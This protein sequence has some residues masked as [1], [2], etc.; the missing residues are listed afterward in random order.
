MS[1]PPRS[2]AATLVVESARRR[3]G[4]KAA[5]VSEAASAVEMLDGALHLHDGLLGAGPHGVEQGDGREPER[6]GGPVATALAGA[7]L[8]G[9]AGEIIST[10]GD[11]AAEIWGAAAS[12]LVRA[13]TLEL[14]DLYDAARPPARYLAVAEM[15]SGSLLSLALR[16]GELLTAPG[17]E[18]TEALDAF[19]RQLGVATEIRADV[20]ALHGD[21]ERGPKTGR[22]AGGSYP[23]P[24]LYSL[25]SDPELAGS[26]GKPLDAEA[27]SA[28]VERVGATGGLERAAEEC[29]QRLVAAKDALAGTEAVEPLLEIADRVVADREDEPA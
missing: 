9:R 24:L 14:E 21:G 27:L 3:D 28:V 2:L 6:D 26:L 25:E 7:W 8:L 4:A 11:E 17:Q 18:A 22:L 29:R 13:R 19:G 12:R 10:C 15:R 5:R 1:S 16:L 23:L 20:A